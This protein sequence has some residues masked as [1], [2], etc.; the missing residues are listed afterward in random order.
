[1]EDKVVKGSFLGLVLL[2]LVIAAFNGVF[3][4]YAVNTIMNYQ[5]KSS[6]FPFYVACCVGLVP[7]IGKL[8]LPVA[9]VAWM[10][11]TFLL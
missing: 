3:W 5:H 7:W 8:G 6:H 9:V 1:M 11:V 2:A 10:A 4:W